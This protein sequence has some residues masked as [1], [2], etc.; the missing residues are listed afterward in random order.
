MLASNAFSFALL[1]SVTKKKLPLFGL[2]WYLVTVVKKLGMFPK[3]NFEQIEKE[4]LFFSHL[5]VGLGNK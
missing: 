1:C 5:K 3:C 2:S 4:N